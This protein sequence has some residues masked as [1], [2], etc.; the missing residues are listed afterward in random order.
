MDSK[1]ILVAITD[2]FFYTKVRDALI[3]HGFRL[4]KARRQQD[5][6]EKVSTTKPAAVILDMS[7]R[8]LDPFRALETLRNDAHT[9]TIPVLAFVSHEEVETWNKTKA[10]GVT[11]LV[12]RSEFSA[13]T[14]TLVEELL[15]R[16]AVNS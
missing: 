8:A 13:N 2:V 3:P 7:E 12:S 4:E 14:R 1:T 11:K 16:Q 6:A 10:L 15:S 5:I 9:K